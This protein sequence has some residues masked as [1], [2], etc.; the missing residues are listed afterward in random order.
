MGAVILKDFSW[1]RMIAAVEE[2]R[3]RACRAA[4]AL[5]QA[6]IPH[7]I[8]GGHAVA[9]WVA[10]VDKE[11][12]RNTKDVD[13]LVRREDLPRVVD[14]LQSIGFI[15]QNVAGVDLFLDGPEGSV[16]SAIH[17]VFAGE[18]VRPGYLLPTPDVAE[19]EPGPDFPVPTLDALVRMKL[20]SF[21]LKDKVHLV[22]LL[23][24]GLIDESWFYR[25]PPEI[26]ARLKEL[27]DERQREE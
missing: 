23:E 6:G 14:A 10:R 26:A 25:L 19:A 8:V 4:A 18:K 27:I 5:R 13:L 24:V 1:A 17:V 3:E 16:R 21:R 11:A 20:T 7:V 12:V 15:H 2:V 9:S 22:D